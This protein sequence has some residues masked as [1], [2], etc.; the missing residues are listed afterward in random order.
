[1]KAFLLRLSF[2]LAPVEHLLSLRLVSSEL[3]RFDSQTISFGFQQS[4]FD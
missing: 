2:G 1:L 4:I 3:G